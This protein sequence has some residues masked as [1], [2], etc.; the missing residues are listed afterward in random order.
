M[1]K[2]I[3]TKIKCENLAPF[4]LLEKELNTSMLRIGIFANNV[5]G[6]FF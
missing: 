5:S 1:A 4:T 2:S 3:R 6:R